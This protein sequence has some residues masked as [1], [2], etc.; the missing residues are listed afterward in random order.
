[1]VAPPE[2]ENPPQVTL[3]GHHLQKPPGAGTPVEEAGIAQGDH[4]ETSEGSVNF[5]APTPRAIG[6]ETEMAARWRPAV[7]EKDPSIPPVGDQHGRLS[8]Q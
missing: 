5:C 4:Q 6:A 2:M 7:P 8:P 1:M 3:G